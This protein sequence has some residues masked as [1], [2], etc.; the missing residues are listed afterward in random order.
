MTERIRT[1]QRL[2]Q[3]EERF[4]HYAASTS[5]YFWEMDEQCRFSYFSER[6][7]EVTGVSPSLL[8]GK[9]R[10]QTGIPGVSEAEFVRHLDN[11]RFR[12]PFR[13]FVH[14]RTKPDG[15]VVWLAING[16]P[17]FDGEGNFKGYRGTGTDIT[18]PKQAEEKLEALNARLIRNA[19]KLKASNADLEQF[20]YVA[21]H[22][23]QEPLRMIASYCQLLQKR[24]GGKLDK[25]ADEFIGFAVDGANRMQTLI[26]DL[27]AYSRVGTSP[28]EPALVESADAYDTALLN[29]KAAIEESGA[30]ITCD[31]LPTV[32]ADKT[33]LTQLFQNLI[34]NAIKFRGKKSPKIHVSARQDRNAWIFSV[35]DDGIGIEPQYADR[36]F[37]IFQRLHGPGEYSGTGI[38]L[39]VCKKIIER[40]GGRIWVESVPG[41]GATFYFALPDRT[42]RPATRSAAE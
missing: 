31:P 22:D 30:N 42:C 37:L 14:P 5:D 35:R 2:R 15:S 16:T 41:A 38:G 32:H 23:L 24:Y 36:I 25:T 7:E 27:L 13:N 10:Q 28:A 19:E 18:E 39:A 9:T 33:Q 17:V 12:R 34:A 29:L 8:L 21:S 6:F 26:N 20:A 4:R 3:G 40:H 11:L 1:E